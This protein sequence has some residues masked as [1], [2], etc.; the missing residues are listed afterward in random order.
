MTSES[1]LDLPILDEGKVSVTLDKFLQF[2]LLSLLFRGRLGCR[3]D[4]LS[5]GYFV[6]LG[7]QR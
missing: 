5:F 1:A 2:R 4:F 3:V 6:V 7:H